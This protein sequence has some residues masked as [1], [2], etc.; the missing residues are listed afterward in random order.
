M[1]QTME[2][3]IFSSFFRKV[4]KMKKAMIVNTIQDIEEVLVL[5]DI[6]APGTYAV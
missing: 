2:S 1:K 4:V 6:E 5:E 3:V